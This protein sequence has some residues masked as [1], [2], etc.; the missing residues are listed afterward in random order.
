MTSSIPNSFSQDDL[1]KMLESAIKEDETCSCGG[2]HS[3][4]SRERLSKLAAK[5]C[6]DANE[7]CDGPMLHKIIAL[8]ILSRLINWHTNIGVTRLTED[9]CDSGVSWLRDAGKLQAAMSL[10]IE[11]DLGPEDFTCTE[12]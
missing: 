11:V 5:I 9:G 2:D 12:D 7:H 1:E 6:D 8:T 10:L 3:D 4:N